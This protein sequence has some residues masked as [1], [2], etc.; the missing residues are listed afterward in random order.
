MTAR[1]LTKSQRIARQKGIE[2]AIRTASRAVAGLQQDQ[3]G[4]V[5]FDRVVEIFAAMKG[6]IKSN[7]YI[8]L[9][10]PVNY[11]MLVQQQAQAAYNLEF[12]KSDP[13]FAQMVEA[14]G[15]AAEATPMGTL[16]CVT[17]KKNWAGPKRQRRAWQSKYFLA[18]EPVTISDIREAGLADNKIR[19]N[20][21]RKFEK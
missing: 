4:R 14:K 13:D 6:L 20:R 15:S 12:G 8:S 9:G 17:W 1:R 5:P 3:E 16:E 18:D 21:A 11:L 10:E 2:E 19:R 7:E